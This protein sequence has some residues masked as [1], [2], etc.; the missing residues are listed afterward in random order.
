MMGNTVEECSF[1]IVICLFIIYVF[2]KS[3]FWLGH[4]KY[5]EAGCKVSSV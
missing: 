1:Y 3:C 2:L 4:V 5:E